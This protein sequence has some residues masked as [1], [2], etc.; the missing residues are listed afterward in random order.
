MSYT[1]L[2]GW[3]DPRMHDRES[4]QKYNKS[5]HFDLQENSEMFSS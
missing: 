1:G 2:N 4:Y 3:N 5:L